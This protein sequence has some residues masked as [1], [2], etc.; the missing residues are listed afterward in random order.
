MSTLSSKILHIKY[1]KNGLILCAY[2]IKIK[3]RSKRFDSTFALTWHITHEHQEDMGIIDISGVSV[4]KSS[5]I[6]REFENED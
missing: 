2:C 5:M 3:D 1:S 4:P 6:K